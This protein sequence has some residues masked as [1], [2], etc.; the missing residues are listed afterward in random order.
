[1]KIIILIV[2]LTISL[3]VNAEPFT[4]SEI[5]IG[6]YLLTCDGNPRISVTF[7][8]GVPSVWYSAK[9]AYAKEYL[10]IALAAKASSSK[11]FFYGRNDQATP[12]CV[13]A[14]NA[15]EI[16]MIGMQ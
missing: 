13:S 11:L 4:G 15:R 9:G 16:Y 1:M 12:Y 6:V 10:S 14:G 8:N 2:A 7:G 5:P 3:Q